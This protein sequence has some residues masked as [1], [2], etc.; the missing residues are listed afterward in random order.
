[1]ARFPWTLLRLLGFAAGLFTTTAAF[2]VDPAATTESQQLLYAFRFDGLRLGDVLVGL[3]RSDIDYRTELRGRARGIL[4]IFDNFRTDLIGE[5]QISGSPAHFQPTGFRRAWAVGHAGSMMTVT[6]DT[7]THLATSRERLFNPATGEDMAPAKHGRER[8]PLPVA[9]RTDVLD[10]LSAFVIGRD[11]LRQDWTNSSVTRERRLSV[12]DGRHRYDV[13]VTS[14]AVRSENIDGTPQ[15][16]VPVLA[17]VEPAAGFDTSLAAHTREGSGRILFSAD[18]RF[19]PLQ[20][21]VGN[22]LGHGTF[23]LIADCRD[24]RAPCD[25]LIEKSRIWDTPSH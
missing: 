10:P 13:V 20:V 7:T 17:R 9:K 18:E 23:T 14:D 16:V 3:H 1:M 6:F 19:L 2:G 22:S 5:G 8:D 25:A 11:L 4:R 15:R 12:F 21:S 24:D